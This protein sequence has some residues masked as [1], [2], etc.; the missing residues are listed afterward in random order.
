MKK[1]T[2]IMI[3]LIT[4]LSFI[5]FSSVKADEAPSS[6]TSGVFILHCHSDNRNDCV[7]S[8]WNTVQVGETDFDKI[9]FCLEPSI[10]GYS[11]KTYKLQSSQ[12]ITGKGLACAVLAAMNE[13]IISYPTANGTYLYRS[14]SEANANNIQWKIWNIADGTVASQDSCIDSKT[15]NAPTGTL[16]VTNTVNLS[17]KNIGGVEYYSGQISV[18][19]S[20]LYD[21]SYGISVSSSDV[22]VSETESGT[23]VTS[24]NKNLLYVRVPVE[25]VTAS[26]SYNVEFSAR[27]LK[28]TTVTVTPSIYYYTTTDGYNIEGV[29]HPYQALGIIGLTRETSKTDA[30]ASA[31]STLN[32]T[33]A[34]TLTLRK[35]DENGTAIRGSKMKVTKNDNYLGE[36]TLSSGSYTLTGDDITVGKYCV[37]EVA[38]PD[39]YILTSEPK[40][41]TLSATNL[42]DEIVMVNEQTLVKFKKVWYDEEKKEYL[43]VSNAVLKIVDEAGADVKDSDGKVI[44]W[45]T[46]DKV[47][48]VKG[49]P[50]GKYSVVEAE[51]PK[52]YTKTADIEFEIKE[53]GSIVSNSLESKLDILDK[54]EFTIIIKED[55]TVTTF[56]KQDTTTGKELPGATLQILDSNK[57][58]ILDKDGKELYKWVSTN[59]PHVI[60]GLPAGKYYLKETIAPEGYK[61]TSEMVAFEVKEDGTT[62]KVVMKNSPII[63]DTGKSS[64]N[65]NT[66]VIGGAALAV[67]G[68]GLV[69]YI[70]IKRRKASI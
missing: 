69:A 46:D 60:E 36:Y 18:S 14:F 70:I 15:T 63:P 45:K 47:H 25:K 32:V 6:F 23:A 31:S 66:L 39:G 9:V 16:S 34:P 1:I 62:T 55:K 26:S 10:N 30:N 28:S 38:S 3:F 64:T 7:F 61:A 51:I 43:P 56:S 21:N 2:Y 41:V 22:I 35:V 24:S 57:K 48:D 12:T 49:L 58:P 65:I 42:S 4:I 29:F 37:T 67:L 68:I 52:G 17:K 20:N 8:E 33:V 40:C 50:V 19:Q 11:G 54:D 13:G 53:D 44:T 59:K 27:Y 5:G